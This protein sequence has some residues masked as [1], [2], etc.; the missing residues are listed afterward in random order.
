MA[1]KKDQRPETPLSSVPSRDRKILELL[2]D[3]YQAYG[4]V[5]ASATDHQRKLKDDKIEP[6]RDRLGY[7]II[8]GDRFKI[9]RQP[10]KM[11]LDE[12]LLIRNMLAIG[13]AKKDDR[14]KFIAMTAEEVVSM[15]HDAKKRGQP[16]TEIKRV[17][18]REGGDK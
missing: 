6:L 17:G 3:R 18:K 14:G 7:E 2:I 10:G 8:A 4:S 9:I 11:T 12:S 16:Y 5:I 13:L 15:V 1:E